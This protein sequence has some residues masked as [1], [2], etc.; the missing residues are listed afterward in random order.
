MVPKGVWEWGIALLCGA[1][2]ESTRISGGWGAEGVRE[3]V[4][5]LLQEGTARLCEQVEH[6]LV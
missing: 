2:Q 4:L 1:K 3:N 6:W 5:W